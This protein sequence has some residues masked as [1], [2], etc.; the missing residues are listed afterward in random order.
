MAIA[1]VWLLAVVILRLFVVSTMHQPGSQGVQPV[2]AGSLQGIVKWDGYYYL[3][4][5]QNGYDF[6]SPSPAFYPL[7]PFVVRILHN[8]GFGRVSAG[9]I[10]NAVAI[11]FAAQGLYRLTEIAT[12]K[13]K[14][15]VLT[16][17]AWL[18]F[19]SA[20]F[21]AAYYTE[22]LFTALAVWSLVFLLRDKYLPA[23][24]LAGLA[25]GSRMVGIVSGGVIFYHYIAVKSWRDNKQRWWIL[26]IPFSFTGIGLYWL[27]LYE[28]TNLLPP[29]LF[30]QIYDK[31]WPYMGFQPN[32]F[33]TFWAGLLAI[34][35]AWKSTSWLDEW[36]SDIFTKSHFFLSWVAIVVSAFLA[37]RKKFPQEL[38][39]YSALTALMLILT[40]N[41][42]SHSRYIL[43]VFPVFIL[44]AMWLDKQ[45]EWVRTLYFVV[46]AIALGAMLTLFSNGY[47]VG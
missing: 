45:A 16:V 33:A 34:F 30:N 5:A 32:I 8:L 23:I 22:A 36:V 35:K 7:F 14:V 19:P 24:L 3:G 26:A 47:W 1:M 17:L 2:V 12:N 39:V 15:T 20:H 41:F 13:K 43:P 42:V 29:T 18:T 37:W 9:V 40:G 4:I 31:Y 10:I 27:W 38:V 11:I 6:N 44:I 46:S 28:K 25:S 21:L